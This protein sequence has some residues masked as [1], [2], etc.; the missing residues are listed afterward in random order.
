MMKRQAIIFLFSIFLYSFS[1][2]QTKYNLSG[3]VYDSL[4]HEPLIGAMVYAKAMN[5]GTFSNN[6]G[7]FNLSSITG[8]QLITF[9]L[10]GYEPRTMEVDADKGNNIMRVYLKE[11]PY[12]SYEVIATAERESEKEKLFARK[13]SSMEISAQ[14]LK[15]MPQLVE[16]D[17]LR[18]LQSMPGVATMSDFSSELYVR[19]GGSDQNLFMIDGVEVYNPTHLFGLLSTFN[20]EAIKQVNFSKGGFGA[21]YGGR[22]SSVVDVV[23]IDGNRNEFKCV[24]D[25]N[26]LTLKATAQMPISDFGSISASF[27]RTYF[28]Q[29]LSNTGSS[30]YF[31]YDGNLKA[32]FDLSEKNKLTFSLFASKDNLYNPMNR[33]VD[34]NLEYNWN[35]ITASFNWQSLLTDNIFT[36]AWVTYSKYKSDYDYEIGGIKETNNISDLT[37][38]FNGELF[39]S[40]E[41]KF[42]SGLEFKLLGLELHQKFPLVESNY[43]QNALSFSMYGSG[44]WQPNPLW[45]IEFGIR[46]NIFSNNKNY[47]HIEPRLALKYRLSESSSLKYAFGIYN[48]YLHRIHRGFIMGLYTMADKDI[49]SSN[50]LH[51]I[52][53]YNYNIAEN[54][55]LEIEL[56]H[57]KLNNIYSLDQLFLI[58]DSQGFFDIATSAPTFNASGVDY[59]KGK[60]YSYGLEILFRKSAGAFTGFIGYT[61][62]KTQYEFSILNQGNPFSPRHHRV[63][64]LNAALSADLLGLIRKREDDRDS[65][66]LIGLN[67]SYNSGQPFSLPASGYKI[68][69]PIYKLDS[70]CIYPTK[71]NNGRLPYYIRLDMSLRY[72]IYYRKWKMTPYLQVFNIG[73]RKNVWAVQYDDSRDD[74]GISVGAKSIGMIPIIPSIG[75][76]V[77]F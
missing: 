66:L 57:K 5:A 58:D 75:V 15:S 55:S 21:E 31:F 7:Y 47:F 61:L 25:W 23:N 64:S 68:L 40:N 69:N 34:Y 49:G 38:K 71:L 39:Y 27:R 42:K 24:A 43:D 46:G 13:I 3:F 77:E 62:A 76:T 33:G 9:S 73:N 17:L 19:G 16:G 60:G 72:E 18:T 45:D 36:N 56:Y 29:F 48:Q 12:T 41:L 50:A 22:L 32:T 65:R 37:M 10:I 52:L 54:L 20:T 74:D 59:L 6:S 1:F 51:N 70:L 2:S 11:K 67:F 53:G 35:N 14:Q 63:H 8:R 26:L 28:D 30:H 44:N 4:T